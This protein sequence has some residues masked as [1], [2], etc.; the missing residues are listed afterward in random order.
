MKEQLENLSTHNQ[1]HLH[2]LNHQCYYQLEALSHLHVTLVV[3]SDDII[4]GYI[5][6]QMPEMNCKLIEYFWLASEW[7]SI[8]TPPVIG[9]V[10]FRSRLGYT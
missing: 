6:G 7:A 3:E 10:G 2:S 9:R 5:G 4:I 8:I 1:C